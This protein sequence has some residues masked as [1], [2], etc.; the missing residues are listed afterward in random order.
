MVFE[1]NEVE[2]FS[3]EREE[4]AKRDGE[5]SSIRLGVV[6]RHLDVHAADVQ[7]REAFG[8]GGRL[9]QWTALR[10]SQTPSPGNPPGRH[11]ER[12]VVPTSD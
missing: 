9:R 8:D 3:V 4:P 1:A 2:Q 11:N 7:A 6:H 10:S 5:R 12:V